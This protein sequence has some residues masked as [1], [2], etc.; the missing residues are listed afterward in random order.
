MN[1]QLAL[2]HFFNRLN[3]PKNVFQLS[4]LLLQTP[5]YEELFNFLN[6]VITRLKIGMT[7]RCKLANDFMSDAKYL[8][9]EVNIASGRFSKNMYLKKSHQLFLTKSIFEKIISRSLSFVV[10]KF[11]EFCWFKNSFSFY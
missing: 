9:S 4:I 2:E 10:A 1:F 3:S 8:F 11:I 7:V 5:N 6:F